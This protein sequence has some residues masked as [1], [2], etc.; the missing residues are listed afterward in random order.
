MHEIVPVA[1]GAGVALVC[2]RVASVRLRRSV[3]A[4]LIVAAALVASFVNGEQ[5]GWPLF[6]AADLCFALAGAVAARL[7]AGAVRKLRP[8]FAEWSVPATRRVAS[9]PSRISAAAATRPGEARRH[10]PVPPSRPRSSSA[11]R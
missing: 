1:L 7:V 2:G 6:I 10:E 11:A 5:P 9:A 8:G 3:F 4:V